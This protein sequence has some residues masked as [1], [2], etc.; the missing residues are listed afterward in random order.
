M[1][2]E[3]YDKGWFRITE[4]PSGTVSR[5]QEEVIREFAREEGFEDLRGWASRMRMMGWDYYDVL[6]MFYR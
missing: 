3:D 4:P 2:A 6:R 1:S 5:A